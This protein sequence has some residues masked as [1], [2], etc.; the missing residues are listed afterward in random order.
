[1]DSS[2]Q[3][4]TV[5]KFAEVIGDNDDLW[6]L[7]VGRE[8]SRFDNKLKY[9]HSRQDIQ[10]V[11]FRKEGKVIE[12]KHLKTSKLLLRVDY[13]TGYILMYEKK[14]IYSNV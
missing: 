11:T 2:S 13:G 12:I 5:Q 9:E 6:S 1:M 7:L 3:I 4:D 8:V 14:S 10:G